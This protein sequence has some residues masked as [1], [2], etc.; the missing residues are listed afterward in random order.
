MPAHWGMY[1]KD[2]GQFDAPS[3]VGFV[4]GAAV[5]VR[6]D[7]LAV[8]GLLD[9]GFFMYFEDAD[10]CK[11]AR[12]AAFR[13]LY[14]PQATAIHDES[15]IAVRGSPSYLRR[16][17]TGRWRY[18]LKHFDSAEIL[19]ETMAAEAAWL[20]EMAG[21]ERIALGWAYRDTA[22]AFPQIMAARQAHGAEAF[23]PPDQE[24]IFAAILT[25]RRSAMLWPDSSRQMQEL[26]QLG[27]VEP[28]PFSS[29]TPVIGPL[30]ARLRALW[31]SVAAKPYVNA[32]NEQQ[33]DFNQDFL[34]EL[35]DIENRL[36][37]FRDVWMKQETGQRELAWEIS[38]LQKEL[39][40]T[41]RLLEIAA[42]K[43]ASL[44]ENDSDG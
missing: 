43:M 13:V 4:T 31:A 7:A 21:D 32:L 37:A 24:A 44:R 18:L 12:R 42:S 29:A 6:R 26:R 34:H 3:D 17:H 33:N 30:L 40:K 41:N 19:A 36:H 16:F 38:A 5:A 22:V 8:V 11:R 20:E 2:D 27:R 23:S 15:A 25:L 28:Q 9:E 14:V 39:D 1:N 10:W 35:G